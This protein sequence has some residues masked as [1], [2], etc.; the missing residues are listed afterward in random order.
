[1]NRTL[2]AFTATHG[3]AYPEYLNVSATPDGGLAVIMRAPPADAG[4]EGATVSVTIPPEQR[5][6][7]LAALTESK[8]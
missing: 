5:A 2:Y 3:R 6:A 1:M 4:Y 8:T 7:L